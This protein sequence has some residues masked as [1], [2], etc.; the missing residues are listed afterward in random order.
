MKRA[1]RMAADSVRFVTLTLCLNAHAII[2]SDNVFLSNGGDLKNIPGTIAG[3]ME[4]LR[5]KS[6]EPQFLVVGDLGGC[7]ATWIGD[8]KDS[9]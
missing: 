9:L 3:A 1:R 7:T 6:F 2:I 4:P 5:Q 8:S